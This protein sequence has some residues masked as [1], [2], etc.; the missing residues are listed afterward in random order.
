MLQSQC[1]EFSDMSTHHHP[2]NDDNCFGVGSYCSGEGGAKIVRLSG[3]HR[4]NFDAEYLPGTL[5]FFQ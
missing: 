4:M 5:G 3:F 2:R 1:S